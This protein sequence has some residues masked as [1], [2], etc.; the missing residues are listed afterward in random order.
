MELSNVGL[1]NLWGMAGVAFV[2]TCLYCGMCVWAKKQ[3]WDGED[4]RTLASV[5][6]VCFG[7]FLIGF[8]GTWIYQ[9]ANKFIV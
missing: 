8:W 3:K 9:V 4:E 6:L 7:A 2:L 5:I 1:L